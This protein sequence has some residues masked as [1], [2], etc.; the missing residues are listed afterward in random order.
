MMFFACEHGGRMTKNEIIEATL[1]DMKVLEPDSEKDIIAELQRRL[2]DTEIKTCDDFKHLNAACCET[3][4]TFCAHFDMKLIDLPDG[5]KA[6]VC[7]AV[8]WAIYPERREQLRHSW[9]NSANG[10]LLRDIFGD[11]DPF[12]EP[13]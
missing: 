1:S 10:K 11:D 6:W 12:S 8:K 9:R 4:H 13:R 2:P 5:T 3:C 7:D